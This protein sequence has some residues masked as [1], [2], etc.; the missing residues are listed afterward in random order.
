MQC[1]QQP[2][3]PGVLALLGR[4]MPTTPSKAPLQ[5]CRP[6]ISG[7]LRPGLCQPLALHL[8]VHKALTRTQPGNQKQAKHKR[9]QAHCV[10]SRTKEVWL[11]TCLS[12]WS[13][14]NWCLALALAL[15]L[16]P[17]SYFSVSTLRSGAFIFC[18]LKELMGGGNTVHRSSHSSCFL[19]FH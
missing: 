2:S 15:W 3:H 16:A 8:W 12:G 18:V 14:G 9:R 11:S 1:V 10:S 19:S 5:A 4:R 6:L 7:A 17:S 13:P